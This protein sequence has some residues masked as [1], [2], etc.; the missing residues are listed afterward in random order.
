MSRLGRRRMRRRIKFSP[1]F[2]VIPLLALLLAGVIYLL[3]T[4]TFGLTSSIRG[5]F[6]AGPQEMFTEEGLRIIETDYTITEPGTE[7]SDT[8]IYENLYITETVGEG[9]VTLTN[10]IVDGSVF[11]RGGG[12]KTINIA[13]CDFVNLLVNR[14]GGRVRLVATGSTVVDRVSLET[15]ARVI[16]KA[17][18]D[19]PGFKNVEIVT[20]DKIELSGRFEGLEFLVKEAFVELDASELTELI[21]DKTGS[22]STLKFADGLAIKKLYFDGS[23]ALLG[24]PGVEEAYIAAPGMTDL[25]GFFNKVRI[26]AE[27]GL[28]NLLGDSTYAEVIIAKDAYNNELFI[29]EEATVGYLELN[30]AAVVRGTGVV[31]LVIVNAAGSTMEQVPL[32]IDFGEGEGDLSIT[33][34]GHEINNT[35]MLKA[36]TEH[37]DPYYYEATSEVAPAPAPEPKPEPEPAEPAPEPKPEPA[38]EE[39]EESTKPADGSLIKDFIVGEEELTVGFKLVVVTLNVDDPSKYTVK[40]GGTTLEFYDGEEK[41]FRGEVPKE[42]AVRDKVKV[43][44]K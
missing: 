4:D 31:D 12:L 25:N 3:I 30:E 1:L 38:P 16:N 44:L 39:N 28:F 36:L 2:V 37:G 32:D 40:V 10:V 34:A 42:D 17:S 14:P 27:A 24:R 29:E 35:L 22:D 18:T 19:S 33:I 7:L 23:M 26:T 15:G 5:L 43:S 11:V 41:F 8:H 13:D 21:V 6:T 9:S 20:T